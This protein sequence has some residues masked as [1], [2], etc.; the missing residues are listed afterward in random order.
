M[1]V[2]MGRHGEIDS[3]MMSSGFYFKQR[4]DIDIGLGGEQ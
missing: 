1:F 3:M 2:G 4:E